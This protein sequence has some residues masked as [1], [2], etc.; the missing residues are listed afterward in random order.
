MKQL[1]FEK[2]KNIVLSNY[3]F[4]KYC[5]VVSV[6]R[7]KECYEKIVCHFGYIYF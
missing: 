5:A 3:C 2:N 1:N 4:Y 7:V 6:L